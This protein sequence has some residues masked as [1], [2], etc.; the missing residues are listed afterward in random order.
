[1]SSGA[2]HRGRNGRV[3]HWASDSAKNHLVSLSRHGKTGNGNPAKNGGSGAGSSKAPAKD[4]SG[5]GAAGS[6]GSK[7]G[8]GGAVQNGVKNGNKAAHHSRGT[9]D[10][11]VSP[12]EKTGV[13]GRKRKGNS[14]PL[15]EQ[16]PKRMSI[17]GGTSNASSSGA[18]GT[19]AKVLS[20]VAPPTPSTAVAVE[21]LK[22]QVGTEYRR[23]LN[24][25]R[26]RRGSDAKQA[27]NRNMNDMNSNLNIHY[28][29]NTLHHKFVSLSVC[30]L[31]LFQMLWKISSNPGGSLVVVLG[32]ASRSRKW[33]TLRTVLIWARQP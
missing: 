20:P 25:K 6:K 18:N 21:S 15:I 30:K 31:F 12:P 27:W 29:L 8:G 32:H 17:S 3:P 10:T 23:L 33:K 5:T 22:K 24:Q 14:P 7:N 16:K 26:Q 4:T 9:V 1:M 2:G 19:P 11:D 13:K 28:I